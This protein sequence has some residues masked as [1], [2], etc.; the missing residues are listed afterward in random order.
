LRRV[1][2]GRP[3]LVL[4]RPPGL[5]DIIA[6]LPSIEALRRQYPDRWL[7]YCTRPEFQAI[8]K[9][10]PAVDEVIGVFQTE[11]LARLLRRFCDARAFSYDDQ[12]PG[13]AS[14][15]HFVDE[16]ADSVG[17]RAPV[18]APCLPVDPLSPAEFR[19][20]TGFDRPAG[21][22]VA[23]HMGP[24]APVREWP[25][26]HWQTLV[27]RLVTEW[28]ATVL[29]IGGN[30]HLVHGKSDAEPVRQVRVSPFALSITESARVLKSC[31]LF[32]GVDSGPLHLAAAVGTQV[33]GIFGPVNPRLRAPQG[34]L[35]VK[36]AE[37]LPCQF[38]HH[39]IPR[40]HSDIACPHDRAC[41][42]TLSP[43]AVFAQLDAW[44]NT[45]AGVT[46]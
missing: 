41:L 33:A 25:A 31:D 32:I 19:R 42:A 46:R 14:R 23:V 21:M 26:A 37:P 38:C 2:V 18:G 22:L 28:D 16:I 7:V 39:H 43:D 3:L 29:R 36:L 4:L 30:R 11:A 34:A 13:R 45:A 40:G 20:L 24:T 1:L 27:N 9:L 44:K 12:L 35:A 5:G 8:P 10:L 6:S 15:R 17:V